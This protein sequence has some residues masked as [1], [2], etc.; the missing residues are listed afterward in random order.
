MGVGEFLALFLTEIDGDD[1]VQIV[2]SSN[3]KTAR[4]FAVV[5]RSC[6]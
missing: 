5:P 2:G 3:T 4:G 1:K 6:S